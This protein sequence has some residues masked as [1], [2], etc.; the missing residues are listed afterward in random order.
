MDKQWAEIEQGLKN[1][2]KGDVMVYT[3]TVISVDEN[4]WTCHVQMANGFEI[5]D[6]HLKAFKEQPNGAVDI[7]VIGTDVHLLNIGRPD[8][9]VIA[10][11]EIEKTVLIAKTELKVEAAGAKLLMNKD[12]IVLNDGGNGAMVKIKELEDNLNSLKDYVE[13]INTALPL[14]F[15][16]IKAG[17]AADGASGASK[18]K[19]DMLGKAITIK[20]MNNDKVKH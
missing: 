15:A 10:V 7:P 18:Y 8:W 9:L 5:D 19:A 20:P 11:E 14:A 12:G 2:L 1:M 4:E 3:G 16:A 6:A 13:A 17:A